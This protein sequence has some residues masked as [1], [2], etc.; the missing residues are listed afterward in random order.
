MA[1]KFK[2]TI[3]DALIG[4]WTNYCGWGRATRSE[5]WWCILVYG[6]VMELM[7]VLGL[8]LIWSIVT[9]VPSICLGARR[10]HD[11]GRSYWNMC[12]ALLPIIGWIVLLVYVCQKGQVTKNQYGPARLKK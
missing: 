6:M 4:Y 10:L 8:G 5:Y 11:T 7:E 9:I 3:S 1:K 12:W 2:N